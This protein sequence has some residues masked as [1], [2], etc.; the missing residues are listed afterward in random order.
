MSEPLASASEVV[1]FWREA[2]RAGDWFSQRSGFDRSFRADFLPLHERAAAGACDGWV[3][4][5]EGALALMILLDQFPRN[6]FRGSARMYATDPQ[7]LGFAREAESRGHMARVEPEM[8][9]FFALP[10]AHSEDVADQELSVALNRRLGQP[11]LEHAEGHRAIIRRFG[12]F[13]HRNPLLGR[14][15]TPEEAEFL[16]KG[17]F[18]G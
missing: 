16:R 2:G 10:F 13:P 12:R 8:R 15:T 14:E 11:W 9:L 6:A 18:R 1:G 4:D 5:P 17:G 7:A 3:F